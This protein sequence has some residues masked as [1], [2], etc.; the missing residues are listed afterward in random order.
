MKV[1]F[2]KPYLSMESIQSHVSG[3]NFL[4]LVTAFKVLPLVLDDVALFG[5]PAPP[6][7]AL[8]FIMGTFLSNHT[9]LY[10]D[11]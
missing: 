6:A 2:T 3:K 9:A 7:A 10:C 5:G 8:S 11:K 1:H 4:T